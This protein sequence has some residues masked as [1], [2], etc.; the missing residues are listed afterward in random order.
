MID[1]IKIALENFTGNFDNCRPL[2]DGVH[3]DTGLIYENYL[4]PNN[5]QTP[6]Q[7]RMKIARQAASNKIYVKGSIRKWGNDKDTFADLTAKDF[8]DTLKKLAQK[9]NISFEELCQARFTQCEIGLNIRTSIPCHEI[10]PMVVRYGGLKKTIDSDSVY[11]EGAAKKLKLYDKVKEIEANADGANNRR[12]L[13][14]LA[15]VMRN[16]NYNLLRIEYTLHDHNSFTQCKLDHIRTIG[17]LITHY[18]DLYEF[19]CRETNRI[20]LLN[21]IAVPS[22]EKLNKAEF[23]IAMNLA[24]H[25]FEEAIKL[26]EAGINKNAKTASVMRSRALRKLLTVVNK[27]YPDIYNTQTL[28]LDVARNLSRKRTRLGAEIP[29]NACYRAL[30]IEKME[31]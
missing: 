19:W 17:D 25:G 14:E 1:W 7:H 30:W 31:R 9:L 23:D 24:L 5:R 2:A 11:F 18:S 6:K 3:E 27:Y 21:P 10:I 16:H 12:V 15:D 22:R 29:I 8:E 4:L 28:R 26:N 13:K 20:T